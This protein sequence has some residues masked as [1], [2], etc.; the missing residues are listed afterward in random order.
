MNVKEKVWTFFAI[1]SLFLL[2]ISLL[3][4]KDKISPSIELSIFNV[5]G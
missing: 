2:V 5:A 4:L 1:Y 3:F